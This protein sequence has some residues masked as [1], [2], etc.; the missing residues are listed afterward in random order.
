[1]GPASPADVTLHG[2]WRFVG[3]G[4]VHRH[5]GVGWTYVQVAVDDGTRLACAEE[6]PDGSRTVMRD[7]H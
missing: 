2:A 4:V 1:V 5:H 7:G 3:R 6:R